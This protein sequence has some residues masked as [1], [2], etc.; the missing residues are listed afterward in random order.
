MPNIAQRITGEIG[1][2]AR[3]GGFFSPHIKCGTTVRPTSGPSWHN[4]GPYASSPSMCSAFSSTMSTTHP[5][6]P[7]MEPENSL[8][9]EPGTHASMLCSGPPSQNPGLGSSLCSLKKCFAPRSPFPGP[10][11]CQPGSPLLLWH[12]SGSEQENS[13]SLPSSHP[14][15]IPVLSSTFHSRKRIQH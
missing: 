2:K 4:R 3:P 9:R 8:P 1:Y 5:E 6:T 7:K 14:Q 13:H 15:W 11:L 12:M 10:I